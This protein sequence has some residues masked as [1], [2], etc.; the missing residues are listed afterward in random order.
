[1]VN[2]SE[3]LTARAWLIGKED[4]IAYCEAYHQY[5]M[6]NMVVPDDAAKDFAEWLHNNQFVRYIG[7]VPYGEHKGV[8]DPHNQIW[9]STKIYYGAGSEYYT[10]SQLYDIKNKKQH[11]K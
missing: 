7:D 10:T 1:M 5:R 9:I 2:M 6:V 8:Q 3:T 11:G 4:V